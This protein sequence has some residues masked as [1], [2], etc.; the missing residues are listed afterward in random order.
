MTKNKNI[1]IANWKMNYSF[2]DAENWLKSFN[3]KLK[4]VNN[5]PEIVVCPP[6]ILIDFFDEFLL[7]EE[8]EILEQRGKV[9]E[10]L[11]EEE[12]EILT[13]KIRKIN[14]G[15]QDCH[16]A[17]NGA[18]TGDISAK[19]LVDAGCK[20][21]I[22]GH[23]ERRK[24]HFENNEIVNKK[25]QTALKNGLIPVVCL[26]E[27]LKI[28]EEKKHLNFVKE[29]ILNSIPK[30]LKIE[31]LIIAYEPIWSIGTGKIPLKEE[32]TEMADFIKDEIQ[33]N[34]EFLIEN[35][36]IIYGGS[37]NKEN[38]KEI[39]KIKNISGLLVGGASLKAEE[40]A[41]MAVIVY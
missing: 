5:L 16:F 40:F 10:D 13:A 11:D 33:K 3:E 24:F 15:G 29:Q 17:E 31:N 26:G 27:D 19:T 41:E 8:L 6:A 14:L 39:M 25:C 20:Y 1:I 7:E 4:H 23:S 12:L 22:L 9:I 21:V 2:D 35:L 28:R 36:K 30:N 34:Q 38:T 37:A 18:Y 32:I